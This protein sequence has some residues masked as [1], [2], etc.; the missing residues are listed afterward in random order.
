MRKYLSFL[1]IS[2]LF[3]SLACNKTSNIGGEI[4]GVNDLET[5]ISTDIPIKAVSFIPEPTNGYLGGQQPYGRHFL[6][7]LN[8]PVFGKTTAEFTAQFVLSSG[9]FFSE[10]KNPVVDSVILSLEYDGPGFRGDVDSTFMDVSVYRLQEQLSNQATYSTS[11]EFNYGTQPIG[12]LHDYPVFN[13]DTVKIKY[14]ISGKYEE[15][16]LPFQMRI[17]LDKSLGEELLSYDSLTYTS[18]SRF[19]EKFMGIHINADVE[20]SMLAFNLLSNSSTT[21]LTVYYKEDTIPKV[22]NLYIVEGVAVAVNTFQHNYENSAAKPF[23]HNRT[24]GDSLLFMQGFS[25][26]EIKVELGDLS[27]FKNKIINYAELSMYYADIENGTPFTDDIERMTMSHVVEESESLVID[28]LNAE[29]SGNQNTVKAV[30]GGYA[31]QVDSTTK[32]VK[33]KIPVFF[34]ELVNGKY[35][36]EFRIR[37]RV[38]S[39][40]PDRSVFYGPQ[41]SKYPMSLKI[42]YT[43]KK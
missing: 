15:I 18:N 23:I 6:G 11:T 4:V 35:N 26:L 7:H 20:N 12:V 16:V 25:G 37:P 28:A 40:N 21:A 14:P 9:S 30:F 24:L 41:H 22:F 13:S 32:L 34:Q 31:V 39:T 38:K 17:P 33:F 36:P 19:L 5:K 10:F 27:Q 29:L 1:V 3:I 42:I 43:E 2:T 8:D